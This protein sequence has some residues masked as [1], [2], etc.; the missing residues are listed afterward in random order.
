[1]VQF[2]ERRDAGLRARLLPIE[3]SVDAVA[4]IHARYAGRIGCALGADRAKVVLQLTMWGTL[5]HC[6]GRIFS[7]YE[8]PR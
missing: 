4:S 1:M 8:Q 6:D 2:R 7:G 3:G 5:P